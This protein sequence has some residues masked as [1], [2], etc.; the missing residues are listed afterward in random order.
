MSDNNTDITEL[1]EDYLDAVDSETKE[2][3]GSLHSELND[4]REERGELVEEYGEDDILVQDI[5][6]DI[7]EIENRLSEVKQ[8]KEKED[9]LRSEILERMSSEYV[10]KDDWL[11]TEVIEATNH[12]LLGDRKE[13][14]RVEDKLLEE[15]AELEEKLREISHAV[16]QIAKS[17]MGEDSKVDETW[18]SIQGTKKEEPFRIVATSEEEITSEE[19][20]ERVEEDID[21]STAN[22]RLK[23]AIHQTP[24]SPYHRDGSG[25]YSLSTAGKYIAD[26][27]LETEQPEEEDET[28]EAGDGQKKLTEAG[29]D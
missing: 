3:D 6:E 8:T 11:S 2:D 18:G 27:Y 9:E 1:A 28:E 10:A 20:S 4:L 15:G 21:K 26:E 14:L 22:N 16:R 7:A 17:E 13:T 23:S 24:I 19:V 5:D 29:D 12:A 25:K